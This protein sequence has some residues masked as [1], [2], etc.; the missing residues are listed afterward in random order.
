MVN[1]AEKIKNAAVDTKESALGTEKIDELCMAC[2]EDF[3]SDVELQ[4]HMKTEH[5]A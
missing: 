1:L 5:R 3:D 2:G 4:E